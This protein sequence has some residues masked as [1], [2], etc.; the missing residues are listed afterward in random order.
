MRKRLDTRLAELEAEH[1]ERAHP[2][3]ALTSFAY[4]GDRRRLQ[5]DAAGR[6]VFDFAAVVE[7]LQDNAA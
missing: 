7:A 2:G 3:A 6:V 5:L 1:P 4:G